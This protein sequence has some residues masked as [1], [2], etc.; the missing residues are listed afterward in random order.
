MKQKKKMTG[1]VSCLHD[2]TPNIQRAR[3]IARHTTKKAH[4]DETL[5]DN[6]IMKV[7]ICGDRNWK[8]RKMIE[9]CMNQLR[10]HEPCYSFFS[11]EGLALA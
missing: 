5:R 1:L 6:L 9:G 3:E 4:A 11:A 8:D 10:A 2:G 7:L